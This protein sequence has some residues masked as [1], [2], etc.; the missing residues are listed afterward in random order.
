MIARNQKCGRVTG[1]CDAIYNTCTVEG[2][3][4]GVMYEFWV[5]G[6]IYDPDETHCMLRAKP[7]QSAT[8]PLC[9]LL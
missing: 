8:E 3:S 4:P 1:H 2:L 7:L 5:R 9:E 6:C